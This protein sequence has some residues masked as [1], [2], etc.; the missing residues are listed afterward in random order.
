MIIYG[1]SISHIR[2]V[3]WGWNVQILKHVPFPPIACVVSRA[4]WIDRRP[5]SV[6]GE[7][8][9]GEGVSSAAVQPNHKFFHANELQTVGNSYQ[10]GHSAILSYICGSCTILLES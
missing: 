8:R 9:G 1:V 6:L 10:K 3:E 2:L 4:G 5:I 7:L